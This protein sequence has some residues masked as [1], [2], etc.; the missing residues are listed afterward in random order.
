MVLEAIGKHWA[1]SRVLVWMLAVAS[2]VLSGCSS[3][4]GDGGTG[5]REA[6]GGRE[7]PAL[8][9]TDTRVSFGGVAVNQVAERPLAIHNQGQQNLELGPIARTSA[10]ASPYTLLADG[11][12]GRTLL[13]ADSCQVAIR[14]APTTQA[15]YVDR[16]VIPSNDPDAPAVTVEVHGT[17]LALDVAIT[18]VSTEPCAARTVQLVVTVSDQE[19]QPVLGL[20][21]EHFTLLEQ[22]TPKAL[23]GFANT[24]RSPIAVGL[25]LDYSS[26]TTPYTAAIEQAATGFVDELDPS[27]DEVEVIK[28]AR[29][30]YTLLAFTTDKTAIKGAIAMPYPDSRSGTAL[31]DTLLTAL[32]HAAQRPRERRAVIVVSDGEDGDSVHTLADVIT[33]ARVHGVP[34]FPIGIGTVHAATLQHLAHETG[35]QFFTAPAPADLEAIYLTLA[36][37][38]SHHYTLAYETS[39]VNVSM[40][41]VQVRVQANNELGEDSQEFLGCPP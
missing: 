30:A 24:Q 22:G 14:F 1:G 18:G 36:S 39:T 27:Q 37:M 6:T 26:S 13:P 28:F 15:E 5:G 4:G 40:V 25:V 31:Y 3:G 11:C 2:F 34:L 12:S 41:S 38:F 35:G 9:V 33:R 10:L 21:A 23:T 7:G 20:A 8:Q 32:E 17:G 19:G 16:F 29:V